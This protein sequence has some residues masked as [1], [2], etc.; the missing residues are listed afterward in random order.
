MR[1]KNMWNLGRGGGARERVRRSGGGQVA[2]L[3]T[4][5]R[6]NQELTGVIQI[7]GER[8][9][10]LVDED[11]DEGVEVMDKILISQEIK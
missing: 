4:V 7:P 8:I 6:T 2:S 3:M 5:C 10:V 11:E 9:G 1:T